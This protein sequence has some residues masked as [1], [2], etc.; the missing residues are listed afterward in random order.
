MGSLFSKKSTPKSRV[1]E[2]DQAV[3]KLKQTR[4]KL[5]QY[6][7]KIQLNQDKERKLA[8]QCLDQGRKDKALRLLKKKKFQD[9]LLEKTDNQLDNLE[10][11]VSDIEFAQCEIKIMEG[12]KSGNEA[13]KE[14]NAIMSLDDVEKILGDTE[15]AVAYQQEIDAMLTGTSIVE[16]DEEEL[17]GELDAMLAAEEEGKMPDV[18]VSGIDM[19][20]VPEHDVGE[21]EKKEVKERPRE[22]V[23]G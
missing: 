4:D 11:M 8:K 3:L 7:K 15:D 23:P 19:P 21:G 1:T 22:L 16:F 14:L 18:P 10:R 2:Q 17:E 12:L 9:G 6:Q 20:E 13:L 5:K